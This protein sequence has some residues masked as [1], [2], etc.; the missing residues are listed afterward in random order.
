[1]H[2]IFKERLYSYVLPAHLPFL[3][4]QMK[5]HVQWIRKQ[6][7]V[8]G[9]VAFPFS[10]LYVQPDYIIR[11]GMEV[12]S[13]I[14]GFHVLFIFIVP[15]TLV[16]TQGKQRWKGLESCQQRKKDMNSLYY[17]LQKCFTI[18]KRHSVRDP[19]HLQSMSTGN[20]VQLYS[21]KKKKNPYQVCQTA[22]LCL[23]WLPT[24]LH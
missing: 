2:Y 17:I 24:L 3:F 6:F 19:N 10:V 16:I 21:K 12:K 20:T 15:A 13:S 5:L 9:E 18:I 22:Y 7:G 14:H 23:S 8:P 1:M 11:D 4:L